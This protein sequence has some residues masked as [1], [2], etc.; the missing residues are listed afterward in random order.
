MGNPDTQHC[1][2]G[3]DCPPF[4]LEKLPVAFTAVDERGPTSAAPEPQKS[5]RIIAFAPSGCI[6]LTLTDLQN[7]QGE[8]PGIE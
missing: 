5:R 2:G 4:L 7:I 3:N 8:L 6:A 1:S